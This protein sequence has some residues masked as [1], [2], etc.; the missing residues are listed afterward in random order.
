MNQVSSDMSRLVA[1]LTD[2]VVSQG[3]KIAIHDYSGESISFTELDQRSILVANQLLA[4]GATHQAR[5]VLVSSNR[6]DSIIAFWG[7]IRAG[8]VA[9]WIDEKKA[10][11]ETNQIIDHCDPSIVICGDIDQTSKLKRRGRVPR[12][13]QTLE[14]LLSSGNDPCRAEPANKPTG[15]DLAAIVYTSGSTGLPSG[16]CLTHENLASIAYAVIGHMPITADDSYLL[17]VPLHYIHGLMQLLVHTIAG[18]T[19]H[20]SSGF[21]FPRLI[22]RQILES[23]VSGFSGVPFHFVALMERGG[24][25]K[26]SLT[27]LRWVTVTG[28]NLSPQNIKKFVS[29][30]PSVEFHIAYGQ[31]ECS[32]R[33]TA[34]LPSKIGRKP[35]S[36]GT[37]IPGVQ[38]HIIGDK[39]QELPP[40]LT[41][42]IVVSGPNIMRGY[43]QDPEGTAKAIDDCGRLHTGD[44]GHFD[45]EGD[46]YLDGRISNLIK[47]AGE[48]INPIALEQLITSMP[49][50]RDAVVHS[51]PHNLYGQVLAANIL[52]SNSTDPD[53]YEDLVNNLHARCVDRF[54][55]VRSP[56]H[57]LLWTELPRLRNGKIN[58]DAIVSA[59]ID[60]AS[61]IIEGLAFRGRP[62]H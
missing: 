45:D 46:L 55:F 18:A 17:L 51:V 39:G 57:Y 30:F 24:L 54:T 1:G 36:V 32:P 40:G 28:G 34:L 31:T 49:S 59:A 8:A 20:L 48:R 5:V 23:R 14:S 2:A 22:T 53:G 58:K 38:V 33:A 29:A 9:I 3:E 13:I 12:Q 26:E 47:T 61:S 43:W 15:D 44:L 42:E 10:A 27:D 56:H 35:D 6:I 7:I 60:D 4:L 41:G 50:V 19:M 52:L 37:P 11:E 21:Q 16:V 62:G 25:L